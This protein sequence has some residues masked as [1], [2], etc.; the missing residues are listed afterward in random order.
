[1]STAETSLIT[2]VTTEHT[3]E[4]TTSESEKTEET[5]VLTT[6]A[7]TTANTTEISTTTPEITTQAAVSDSVATIAD[8]IGKTITIT[9][10]TAMAGSMIGA[11]EG[12]SF[13][14]D[15]KKFEIYKFPTGHEK[16]KEAESGKVTLTLQ[17]FGDFKSLS[18][19]NGDYMMIYST[20]NDAVV[21]A[22]Q[23][24]QIKS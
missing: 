3:T 13:K 18:S 17:G 12:I 19:V 1:L 2:T 10:I 11:D 24:Y 22:F 14:V 9:D 21:K 6:S 20:A 5:T 15:G 23:S 16:L 4:S 7:T 8:E